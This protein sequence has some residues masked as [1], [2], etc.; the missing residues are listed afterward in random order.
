MKVFMM[1]RCYYESTNNGGGAFFDYP[2]GHHFQ[3][4]S[5]IKNKKIKKK[6]GKNKS[7]KIKGGKKINKWKYCPASSM[8]MIQQ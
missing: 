6:E 5:S 3:F 4:M 8:T 2:L 1:K 7:L